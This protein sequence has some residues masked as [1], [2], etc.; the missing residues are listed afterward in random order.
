MKNIIIF[1]FI[2]ALNAGV[3]G[4]NLQSRTNN[5]VFQERQTGIS[6]DNVQNLEKIYSYGY[7][8]ITDTDLLADGEFLASTSSGVFLYNLDQLE[9]MPPLIYGAWAYRVSFSKI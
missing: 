2:I 1:I 8:L 3:A 7:G 6:L 5:R 9:L 4:A